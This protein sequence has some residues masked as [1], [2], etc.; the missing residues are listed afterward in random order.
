MAFVTLGAESDATFLFLDA[1]NDIG[2]PVRH[3]ADLATFLV[4]YP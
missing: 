1:N 4:D 3:N 2:N